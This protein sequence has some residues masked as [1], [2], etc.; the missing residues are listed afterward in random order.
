[1]HQSGICDEQPVSGRTDAFLCVAKGLGEGVN[2]GDI[3]AI[4]LGLKGTVIALVTA[5]DPANVQRL[6]VE[7]LDRLP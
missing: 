3:P 6:L 4:G 2:P 7:Q 5:S 1:V